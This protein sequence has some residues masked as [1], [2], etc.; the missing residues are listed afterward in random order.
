MVNCQLCG[1]S[2]RAQCSAL[3]CDCERHF[4]PS[5]KR[6][7]NFKEKKETI[8]AARRDPSED[9]GK[10]ER[11]KCCLIVQVLRQ[12]I[13]TCDKNTIKT[14]EIVTKENEDQKREKK[15]KKKKKLNVM[16]VMLLQ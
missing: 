1:D 14:R 16:A 11:E 5:V 7:D 15:K 8:C 13:A 6:R 2:A 4:E 9:Q 3:C 12:W 10:R